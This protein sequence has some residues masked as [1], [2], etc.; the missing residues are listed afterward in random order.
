MARKEWLGDAVGH[1]GE[2]GWGPNYDPTGLPANGDDL[3]YR[4]SSQDVSLQL[5]AL[6]GVQLRSVH[7]EQSYTGMIGTL[8]AYLELAADEFHIGRHDGPGAPAGSPRI[9]I[10]VVSGSGGGFASGSLGA[11]PRI[12]VYNTAT[13]PQETNLPPVRMLVDDTDAELHVRKGS[14]GVAVEPGEV[15]VLGHLYES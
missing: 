12:F 13:S 8:A 15:S 3:H 1:V 6:V 10:D 5:G 4:E 9:K 11:I 14:V 7:V 2:A